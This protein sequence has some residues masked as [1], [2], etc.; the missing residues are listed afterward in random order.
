MSYPFGASPWESHRRKRKR[1]S[2]LKCQQSPRQNALFTNPR[3]VVCRANS[4]L[5]VRSGRDENQPFLASCHCV[6]FNKKKCDHRSATTKMSS[7]NFIAHISVKYS[8]RFKH[9]RNCAN[10]PRYGQGLLVRKTK[11]AHT[12]TLSRVRLLRYFPRYWHDAELRESSFMSTHSWQL[13]LVKPVEA[14]P[15]PINP[16]VWS[17]SKP[18]TCQNGLPLVLDSTPRMLPTVCTTSSQSTLA[19]CRYPASSINQQTGLDC[20]VCR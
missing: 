13:V 4:A 1:A 9:S 15:T 3:L 5:I 12:G 6:R 11:D 16:A 8:R 19:T 18:I 14:I 10:T 17:A 20:S 2:C 7:V